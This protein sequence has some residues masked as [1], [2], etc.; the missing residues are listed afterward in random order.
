[1]ALDSV[2]NQ[3]VRSLDESTDK[4]EPQQE[5]VT[6]DRTGNEKKWQEE[7]KKTRHAGMLAGR[8]TE[9]ERDRPESLVWS[10]EGKR[11][12]S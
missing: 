4:L 7:H 6:K 3:L 10:D 5:D 1:M 8:Q 11:V 12:F 2:S 9:S